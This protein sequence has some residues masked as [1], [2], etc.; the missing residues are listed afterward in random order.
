MKTLF[1]SLLL[2]VCII[3]CTVHAQFEYDFSGVDQLLSDSVSTIRGLSGGCALILIKDDEIIYDKS[4]GIFYSTSKIVPIA[5]AT[6]WLSAAVIMSL[7]KH[8]MALV[9]GSNE[10]I[11][12]LVNPLN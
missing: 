9:N 10:K 1:L 4:F 7:V 8:A 6:K 11:H 12:C 5:S 2:I 3:P